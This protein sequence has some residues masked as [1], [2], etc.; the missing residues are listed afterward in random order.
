MRLRLPELMHAR[1]LTAYAIA[2][3]ST[4]RISISTAYRLVEMEG[5][6]ETFGADILDALCDVLAVEPDALFERNGDGRATGTATGTA[7]RNGRPAAK[8]KAGPGA[9]PKR[10]EAAVAEPA[11]KPVWRW[12]PP[13]AAGG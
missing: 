7:A 1:G 8:R 12:T 10:A 3:R 9:T 6:L 11:P 13:G 5:R 2:K 4:G